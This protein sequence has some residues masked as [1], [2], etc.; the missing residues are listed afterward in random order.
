LTTIGDALQELLRLPGARYSC[1]VDPATGQMI[2]EPVGDPAVVPTV[3]LA[4]GGGAARYLAEV[5][6]DE[7]DDL[8][9]TSR[10]SY[11]LVRQIGTLVSG[12]LL[13]YLCLDRAHGNL[14][15]ARRE[16]GS[17]RLRER[18]LAGANPGRSRFTQPEQRALPAGSTVR[19]PAQATG[20]AAPPAALPASMSPAGAAP[21]TAVSSLYV[22]APVLAAQAEPVV[23]RPRAAPAA[24]PRRAAAPLPKPQP[25][26]EVPGA[27]TPPPG[28]PGSGVTWRNDAEVLRRL[29]AALRRKT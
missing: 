29:L 28:M 26:P 18:L 21:A 12:G 17:T 3:L 25:V 14:A 10:R 13:I 20:R 23:P 1:L 7:L 27:P 19:G 15:A 9:V 11:H 8:I 24:L 4:W 6:A 22:A 5:E 2:D 16:L